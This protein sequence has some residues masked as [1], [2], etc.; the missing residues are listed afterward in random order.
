MVMPEIVSPSHLAREM[1][2]SARPRMGWPVSRLP[3]PSIV[4]EPTKAMFFRFSP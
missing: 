3:P 2:L 4:P 1:I